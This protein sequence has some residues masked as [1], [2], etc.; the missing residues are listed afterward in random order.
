MSKRTC[1]LILLTFVPFGLF[2]AD[3]VAPK[4]IKSERHLAERIQKEIARD[5]SLRPESRKVQATVQNGV[6]TLRGAVQSDEESQAVLGDAESVLIH[7]TPSRLINSRKF[8][9][10][11]QLMVVGQ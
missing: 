10:D 8:R 7:E 3:E 5:D 4:G 1:N 11:N 2:A 6:I 9:F